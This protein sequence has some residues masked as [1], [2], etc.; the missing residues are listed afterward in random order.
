VNIAGK[1]VII[2]GGVS[3]LG[4][5]T[6]IALSSRGGN[7]VM[8]DVNK[9]RGVWL[10]KQLGC[11]Q[12]IETD[13]TITAQ[14]ENAIDFAV[15]KFGR[16]DILVNCAGIAPGAKLVGK[17]G[18][19]D[20]DLFR[21]TIEINLIGPFDAMRLAAY[22]MI[23]NSPNEDGERGVIINTSSGAAF[24]GQMGQS[25]YSASKAALAG[26][27]LPLARDLMDFGIRV[28]TIA[29]GLY[30]TPLVSGFTDK[31]RAEL[32][33]MIPFPRRLGNP[34]EFAMLVQQI[35]ENPYLNG[36]TIRIDG[37]LRMA[38]K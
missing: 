37:A 15:E 29:P 17:K 14:V 24:E 18:P 4:E 6:S 3:G 19:H 31:V 33:S 5:A 12:F 35:I 28:C 20:L 30:N 10:A 27:T 13:I 36:E 25:A 23:N 2:T 16:I 22:K 8:L 1:T 32:V 26:M 38:P 9:E 7:I 11:A 21:R 34:P